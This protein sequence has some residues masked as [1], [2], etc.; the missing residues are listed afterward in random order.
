[1]IAVTALLLLMAGVGALVYEKLNGNLRG[2]PLFGGTTGDA[3]TE[4]PDAFGRTPINVL[5]IGSDS[6]ATPDDC[7]IGGD[8]G[9]G[10]NA[11]VEMLVHVSADRSNSTVLSVP[12]D[13]VAELPACRDPGGT[14]V[15]ARREQINSTLRYGP[16]CTVAAVHQLTGIP[17]DHFMMVDFAGVVKLSDA[18][19]GVGVCVSDNVYDPYSHLKLSRGVHTL[20]GMAALQ[21][22]R[23]RHGFGDGGDLGRT[24]AQHLYLGALIRAM[25]S[26]GTLANPSAVYALAD[27]ATKALTVDTGLD[28]IPRL[29]G[30]AT[31]MDKVPPRRVTFATMQN[32]PDPLQQGRVVVAP[33][34][35]GLFEAIAADRPLTPPAGPRSAVVGA[36]DST[37]LPG[38]WADL[39]DQA[40][41]AGAFTRS[42][43]APGGE[44]PAQPEPGAPLAG[45]HAQTADEE[46]RCAPVSKLPTVAVRGVPMTPVQAYD[47]SPEVPPSAP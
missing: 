15:P 34:A 28:S 32:D 5:V 25:K 29:L 39:V 24:Y 46:G 16:G 42:A 33:A 17:I 1:M 6:R 2:L 9:P 27:A 21:F 12:R 7:A 11:D 45:A 4:K 30:L 10:Q 3:G 23:S 43:G 20:K 44:Q 14:V 47:A 26:A 38:A 36:P 41:A 19:G 31:D 8:C 18:A 13:T 35:R 37:R 22:V 40:P